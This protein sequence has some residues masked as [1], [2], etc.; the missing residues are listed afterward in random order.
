MNTYPAVGALRVHCSMT[1][2]LDDVV[3]QIEPLALPQEMPKPPPPEITGG[4]LADG[5]DAG[6]AVKTAEDST[7][8]RFLLAVWAEAGAAIATTA[9][10]DERSNVRTLAMIFA[11]KRFKTC[12]SSSSHWRIHSITQAE[13]I[14]CA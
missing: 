14:C 9:T 4:L 12:L 13:L 3:L 7:A 1:P 2:K 5:P 10:S 8:P 11:G 6:V